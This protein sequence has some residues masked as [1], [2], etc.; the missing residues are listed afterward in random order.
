MGAWTLIGV[1]IIIGMCDFYGF[2]GQPSWCFR[3]SLLIF[4]MRAAVDADA[5][6]DADVDDDCAAALK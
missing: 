2:H 3:F 1:V 6:T 5:D 4:K